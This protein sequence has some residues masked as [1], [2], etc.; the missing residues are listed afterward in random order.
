MPRFA[1]IWTNAF[2]DELLRAMLS[3]D[4]VI[5]LLKMVDRVQSN[6][7]LRPYAIDQITIYVMR[8]PS[9]DIV[10][11][12][13]LTYIV[14]PPPKDVEGIPGVVIPLVG[15]LAKPI[16]GDDEDG[17]RVAQASSYPITVEEADQPPP[18]LERVVRRIF[19]RPPSDWQ[20]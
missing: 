18:E 8:Q 20:A 2:K 12:L 7:Y 5:E 6:P 4:V 9:L 16:F 15:G 17:M 11:P 3:G 1:V 14:A 10:E 19:Q 13:Y